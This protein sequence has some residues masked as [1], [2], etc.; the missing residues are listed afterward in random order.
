M[1][2]KIDFANSSEYIMYSK[3][4]LNLVILTSRQYFGP[5]SIDYGGLER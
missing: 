4:I 3:F 2:E 1:R 5:N